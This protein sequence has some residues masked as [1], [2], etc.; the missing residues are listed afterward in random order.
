MHYLGIQ[1]NQLFL[2][3]LFPCVNY[4]DFSFSFNRMV[5]TR[6]ELS[7]NYAYWNT[8]TSEQFDN[9]IQR[10][11]NRIFRIQ[12]EL[13]RQQVKLEKLKEMKVFMKNKTYIKQLQFN[14]MTSI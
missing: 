4:R 7:D 8:K 14:S 11:E 6:K 9:H 10:T 5:L 13:E 1:L 3:L 2:V 12:Q